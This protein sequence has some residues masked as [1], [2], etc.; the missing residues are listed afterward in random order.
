MTVPTYGLE[1]HD[2]LR[3]SIDSLRT[4]FET[5]QLSL[6]HDGRDENPASSSMVPKIQ[7]AFHLRLIL[8]PLGG[9]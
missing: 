6:L 7:Y 1:E 4:G 5:L 9:S 8:L 3:H 2:N